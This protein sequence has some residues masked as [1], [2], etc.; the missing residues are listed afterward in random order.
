[1]KKSNNCVL[2]FLVLMV[3]FNGYSQQEPKLGK[4]YDR[5]GKERLLKDL[6]INTPESG[7]ELRRSPQLTCSSTSY[8][9]L[10]FEEGSGMENTS[11]ATHNARRAV[12][13]KVF[14]DL[15]N[16]INS[17]LTASGKKV[18]IWVKNIAGSGA[19][20][21]TLGMASSYYIAPYNS[22]IPTGGILDGEMWKTI[23]LG[24][25]S[26]TNTGNSSNFYH[27]EIAF[28]F[29][30]PAIQWHTDLATNAPSTLY[31]LYTVMLHEVTH[32]LG[33]N[34]FIDQ[35]GASL[36]GAGYY[37]R[38]DTFLRTNTNLPLLTMGSCSMYDVTFNPAVPLTVLRP[39]CTLLDNV[40]SG[41]LNT[42]LC[43]NAIKYVGSFT[44]PVYTPTCFEPGSSLSHFEDQLFP[45]CTSP[46]GN[47]S[48]FVV[49]NS[50]GKGVTK[51]YLKTEERRTLCDIGYNVK[52][53]YGSSTTSG[54]FFNY[55]GVACSGITVAGVND[56]INPDGSYTFMG[57]IGTVGATSTA[58][59]ISGILSNDVNATGFECLQ[60]I[61]AA[62]TLSGTAGTSGTTI[63][64]TTA[65]PGLHLLRYVPI[66]G[67]QRGNITYIHVYILPPPNPGS[68]S[69]VPTACNLVMNGD[70]EQYSELPNLTR[71]IT[72]ACGW[73][74]PN[75]NQQFAPSYFNALVEYS[76]I[77]GSTA[78]VPCNIFGYQDSNNNI[79][80]GYANIV[81]SQ[82]HLGTQ[83][84]YTTLKAP[85]QP[86]TTYQLSFD[87]SLADGASSFASNL[88]AYLSATE[89]LPLNPMMELEIPNPAN[90]LTSPTVTRN[91]SGWDTITFTFT[92]TTG[93]EQYLY[94]GVLNNSPI[95]PN[96]H[97]PA[98][99]GC[100]YYDYANEEVTLPQTF[101]RSYYLDN[102]VLIP[103]D[104]S[105]LE[106][107]TSICTAQRL[108]DLRFYLSN[109]AE[110]GVFSGPGVT[111]SNGVYSFNP[112]VAGVGIITIGYTFTNSTGCPTTLYDTI[113]VKT[114]GTGIIAI[115]AINDNFSGTPINDTTGGIT[116]SIYTND[117]YNGVLS[118]PV[119][120]SDVS[121][122][123]VAP[124]SIPGASITANGAIAVPA[125]TPAGTYTLTYSL[126]VIGNCSVSDTATVTIVV[127]NTPLTPSVRANNWIRYIE[128]QSTG[129]M[130]ITGAFT[131]Y[132]NVPKP[133]IARLNTDL[134]L[135]PTFNYTG[136]LNLAGALAIQP[137]DRIIYVTT[138]PAFASTTS[139]VTRLLPD[140]SVDPSF[141]VGGVG[142]ARH[143]T[144]SNNMGYSVAIQ[145]NGRILVGGDFY[146]YNGQQRVGIVRL[147]PDGTLDPSFNPIE[148]NSYYRAVTYDIL[149]QPDGKILL[150][151]TFSPAVSPP[152]T[153]NIIRLNP[154]GT[155]DNGFLAGDTG[156]SVDYFDLNVSIYAPLTKMALQPN[157]YIVVVGGFSKYNG[158]NTKS[159]VRLQPNGQIDPN[160]VTNVGAQR[161]INDVL[162]EPVTN[163]IIIGGEFTT[164]AGTAV[165]KMIRLT[166]T[167]TL[168]SSFSIGSGTTDLP[169]SAECPFCSNYVKALKRQPDG[170]IIVGGSFKTF[171]GQTAGN[172]TRI[173]GNAGFQSRGGSETFIS[174]P[175]IDINQGLSNI[176]VY[177][178]PSHD[179]F[180][181]DLSQESVSYNSVAIYNLLGAKIYTATLTPKENNTIDLSHLSAGYYMAKLENGSHTA[182]LKL[183]KN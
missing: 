14:E 80:N 89:I 105:E 16:F 121:M 74:H 34:S 128:L 99:P 145:P 22:S 90:L 23:H 29:N 42:T 10:Y 48:Y 39:G 133:N 134:T 18:N 147:M 56:G 138:S 73:N 125:N 165:K 70:F 24:V 65:V 58:V 123:L 15:S 46:H 161:G 28:N 50:I 63:T 85:L 26:Y 36:T 5:F 91:T 64:F 27:G 45:S 174:E 160:F 25:D 172:I 120:L 35:N 118:T 100:N 104:G 163:K 114:T 37:T 178:N 94:L 2:L 122:A 146:Y 33:F 140:G 81:V 49:S 131:T 130:I 31:D 60:D 3:F 4:V 101:R 153:K 177:P 93:G 52:N 173:I 112:A 157:G 98:T 115:D 95:V 83:H 180:N 53:V 82:H 6:M 76:P 142:T 155:L 11:N 97:A 67:T 40:S 179:I 137:N 13:C 152:A 175:E 57:S 77:Y 166:T 32:A 1:M 171:N 12:V 127:G 8:F 176:K 139:C 170:K 126:S 108:N 30:N 169:V 154:N 149:V 143:S 109:V 102:V 136:N 111:V 144:R 75:P 88:Q 132:N 182:T 21:G 168:D 68:C 159:I 79:G 59:A 119:S 162:I 84:L 183:I 167:G 20:A 124:V 54:G 62:A 87:A 164:F 158:I 61:T 69:P 103:T 72:K 43:N 92:T 7:G 156:G 78:D 113:E 96:T 9:N 71:E 151:G 86:N 41:S 107:P 116:A 44:V 110:N 141:N 66:N 47:D 106:L 51:R 181:I 150:L 38:Y 117:K 17:P 19:P 148:L 135:D 129:K 55:S